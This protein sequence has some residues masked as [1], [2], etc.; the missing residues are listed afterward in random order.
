MHIRELR[1][2]NSMPLMNKRRNPIAPLRLPNTGMSTEKV[3]V[4][5]VIDQTAVER[6][7]L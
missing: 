4:Y 2:V 5:R 7:M 1:M 3:S 6:V